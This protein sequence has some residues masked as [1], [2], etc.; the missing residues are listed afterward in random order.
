MTPTPNN[1][2]SDFKSVGDAPSNMAAAAE[3]VVHV[4]LPLTLAERAVAYRT[5]PAH[6]RRQQPSAPQRP[7]RANTEHGNARRVLVFLQE[8][9]AD[10]EI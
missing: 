7:S 9:G 6:P 8:T 3:A 10:E 1:N 4:G 2:P 5:P